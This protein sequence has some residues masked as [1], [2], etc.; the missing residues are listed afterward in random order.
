MANVPLP[1]GNHLQPSGNQLPPPPEALPPWLAQDV[2][3]IPGKQHPLPKNVERTLPKFDPKKG[4]TA[5]NHIHSFFLV[6]SM[7]GVVDEDIVCFLFP[8][9][10]IGAAYTWYFSLR[11]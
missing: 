3:M 5:D 1:G 9:T 10:L 4:D 11:T 8:F 6:E 2:V 7:L